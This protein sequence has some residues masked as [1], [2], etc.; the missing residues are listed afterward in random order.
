MSY[1]EFVPA[2]PLAWTIEC[3]WQASTDVPRDQRVL[4][5]GCMDLILLD[6][7]VIVAG[8]DT[9]AHLARTAPGTTT[10]GLRFRP[11]AL[12]PLL[13]VPADALRD[14]RVPLA[15]LLPRTPGVGLVERYLRAVGDGLGDSPV[16]LGAL[17]GLGGRRLRVAA[18]P[19]GAV[20]ALGRGMP[21]AE[22]AD[23]LGITVRTLHRRCVGTLGYGPSVVRRV[24]RFRAA[25]ALLFDGVPP[26]E[27]AVR[28]GYAD[29]PHLSREVRALAGVSPGE[30][31]GRP[32]RVVE[33]DNQ[34]GS[35]RTSLIG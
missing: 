14:H 30:L 22:V 12:P 6:D 4:P 21:A 1:R 3:A 23:R 28:A 9:T 35:E 18:L 24:L 11:G 16:P 29:Q 32:V 13:G 2:G 20:R 33:P 5:D 31:A 17:P 7:R 25:G 19:G 8:P 15:E 34:C 27:V 26:A 10:T